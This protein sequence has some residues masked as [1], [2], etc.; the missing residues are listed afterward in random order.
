MDEN[1]F[2][3]LSLA[4]VCDW[5]MDQGW[6][7]IFEGLLSNRYFRLAVIIG[8]FCTIIQFDKSKTPCTFV[9]RVYAIEV[10]KFR[11]NVRRPLSD[12]KN[13]PAQTVSLHCRV[14]PVECEE[15][16]IETKNG[17]SV[18]G[19]Q[20]INCNVIKGCAGINPLHN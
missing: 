7:L 10:A 12:D 6:L 19:E 9:Y 1:K 8:V 2:I 13:R 5:N 14:C 16:V 17:I 15:W 18:K 4:F 3:E 20:L 11:E